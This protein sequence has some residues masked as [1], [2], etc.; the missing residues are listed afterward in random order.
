MKNNNVKK[1]VLEI[2]EKLV[3][4]NTIN[5]LENHK[6]VEWIKK[7]LDSIGFECKEIIDKKENKKCLIAKIGEKQNLGFSGHLDTVN[8]GDGWK[9]NAFKLEKD[10]QNAY[11]LGTCDMKRRNIC[12]IKSMCESR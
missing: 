2:L 9:N 5:D 12:D 6:I 11:G 8:A 3:S 4:F 10:S 1:D 7:Y